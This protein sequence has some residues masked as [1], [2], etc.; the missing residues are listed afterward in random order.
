[1]VLSHKL[2]IY[3]DTYKLILI[4]FEQTKHFSREYKYTLGQDMKRDSIQLVRSIYRANRSKE[5]RQYLEEFLD[6]F[7]ILKL[8]VRLSADLKLLSIKHLSEISKMLD[9][10]GK[11]ATAWKNSN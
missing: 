10:I 7:E 9:L 3:K 2:P 4:I 8:E 5:K 11:Q 1:M 6:N